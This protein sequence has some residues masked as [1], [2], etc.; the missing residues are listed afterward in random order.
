MNPAAVFFVP[1]ENLFGWLIMKVKP[2]F[3]AF[4]RLASCGN[5]IPVYCDLA[6]DMETPVS[7]YMRIKDMAGSFL[8]ESAETGGRWGQYSY[9]GYKP[10]LSVSFRNGLAEVHKGMGCPVVEKAS[11][12][13]L[14]LRKIMKKFHPVRMEGLPPFQ[15][16]LVGFLGYDLVRW[17]ERVPGC[18]APEGKRD[19]AVFV[20][21]ERMVVFNHFT[22]RAAVISFARLEDGCDPG[23]A[24]RRACEEIEATLTDLRRPVSQ[25]KRHESLDVGSFEASTTKEAFCEKVQKAKEYLYAGDAM[26][27]V[28][29]QSFDAEVSGDVFPLYRA[30]RAMNPSPYM[31]YLNLGDHRLV[32]SSPEILA[33]LTEGKIELRP[34]AGTR[35]R[36]TDSFSDIELERELLADAKE[37]AEHLMLVDLGRN[38][39]GKVARAGSVTVPRFMEVE[40]YSHVMHLV[41]R[42]EAELAEG[43]DCFDLL[44]SSF[45]AGTVSGAPKVR[46]MEIIAELENSPRGP[47]AG[48]AGYFGFNGCM[49]LCITI[50]TIAVWRNLLSVQAGAGIVADSVP[51]REYEETLRKAAAM[52][53]AVE[54][55]GDGNGGMHRQL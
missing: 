23:A 31:F 12:P 46:A 14:T 7:L 3:D 9:L 20:A 54:E 16:G 39:A 18:R 6:A 28:L 26:Q 34:I 13:I 4:L 45:P 52:L 41:S 30:L 35:P 33:R 19:E 38:D 11:D 36:G 48:A 25:D 40:R 29:S 37:R 53:R 22:D 1:G 15:G 17:W 42:V 10:F 24:Y 21:P 51:E 43:R 5:L 27:I 47:Y 2:D 8:L 55:V 50:R 49:D 44:M 32:G